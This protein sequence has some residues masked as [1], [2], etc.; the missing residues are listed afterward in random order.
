MVIGPLVISLPRLFFALGIAAAMLAAGMLERRRGSRVEKPLWLSLLAGLLVARVGYVLTHLTAF[1]AQPWQ[2]L[3]LWQGGYLPW[4]GVAAAFVVLLLVGL[5]SKRYLLQPL[6]VPLVAALVVW[7]GLSWVNQALERATTRPLP[8]LTLQRLDGGSVTLRSFRGKPVVLNLWATWCPPCRREMPVLAAAQQGHPDVRF[9]FVNQG[10]GQQAIHNYLAAEQLQLY[11][12]LLDTSRGVARYFGLR[13][14]PN[15]L[16]FNAD[17]QL[18]DSHLGM[19]TRATLS[20][21]LADIR[22]ETARP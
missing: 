11:N 1:G 9:L 8:A 18:V 3:Y 4:L 5:R 12:V 21:Y 17:G 16:F 13:G 22:Q 10:E 14:L 7:G 15:T 2:A 19:L 6:L 20:D